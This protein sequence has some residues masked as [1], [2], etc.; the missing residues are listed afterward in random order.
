LKFLIFFGYATS[1]AQ[2]LK[3]AL[4]ALMILTTLSYYLHTGVKTMEVNF[5]TKAPV[6]LEPPSHGPHISPL[7]S[8][9]IL[10]LGRDLKIEGWHGRQASGSS[11]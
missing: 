11:P 10:N 3:N 8:L 7:P 2:V 1:S 5:F 4:N 6:C 9:G